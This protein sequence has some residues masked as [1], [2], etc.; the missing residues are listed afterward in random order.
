MYY[1]GTPVFFTAL[2]LSPFCE[3]LNGG[4]VSDKYYTWPDNKM[5]AFIGRTERGGGG[6]GVN[7]LADL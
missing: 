1:C 5:A 2:A 7:R 3:N 6:E 4:H